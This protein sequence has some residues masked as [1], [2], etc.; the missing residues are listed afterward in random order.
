MENDCVLGGGGCFG[1]DHAARLAFEVLAVQSVVAEHTH[2]N[3]LAADEDY[4]IAVAR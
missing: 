1:A 2:W 4:C 3:L